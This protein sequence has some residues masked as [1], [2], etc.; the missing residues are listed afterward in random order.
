MATA[1]KEKKGSSTQTD[2]KKENNKIKARGI[3]AE[4]A[5]QK[6]QTDAHSANGV[7]T[8]DRVGPLEK[9]STK[10]YLDLIMPLHVELLK[11]QNW[12]KDNDLR[13]VAIFEGRMR[14]ER[15]AP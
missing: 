1:T 2:S 4:K 12:V 8:D 11:M 10:P 3:D 6:E 5:L 7:P 9:L 15:A 13:V 14:R